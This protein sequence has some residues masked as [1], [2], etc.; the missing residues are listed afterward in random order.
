[1]VSKEEADAS[2]HHEYKRVRIFL[3]KARKGTQK[4][5]LI[6]LP[7]EASK[8]TTDFQKQR[9]LLISLENCRRRRPILI[10]QAGGGD[11]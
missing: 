6:N 8:G 1:M 10:Y 7:E 9:G 2:Q 11:C 5:A 3:A 4:L